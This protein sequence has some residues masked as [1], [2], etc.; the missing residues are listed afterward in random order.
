[1]TE[2]RYRIVV[3]DVELYYR[4]RKAAEAAI[5]EMKLKD[6]VLIVEV[7]VT[8]NSRRDM[9]LFDCARDPMEVLPY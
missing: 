3:D 7:L 9:Q 5:T 8:V 6:P 1:M 4:T 2:T